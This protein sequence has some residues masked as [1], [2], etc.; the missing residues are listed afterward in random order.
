M[1]PCSGAFITAGMDV[2]KEA[3]DVILVDDALGTLIPAVEEGKAIF[4]NV[5][6]FLAFQLSTAAAALALITIRTLV[7]KAAPLNPM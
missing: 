4:H 2:V 5:R 7:G 3:A 1:P 6:N